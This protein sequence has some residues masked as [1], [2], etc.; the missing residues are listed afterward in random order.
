MLSFDRSH[1]T[2]LRSTPRPGRRR[3]ISLAVLVSGLVLST[4]A[5]GTRGTETSSAAGPSGV[6]AVQ[7]YDASQVAY[8]LKGTEGALP[9]SSPKP[10]PGK[11]VWVISC[12]QASTGCAT[13]ANDA[14]TAGRT[15]GW[16]MTL[17]DGKLSLQGWTAGIQAAIAAHAD[18]IILDYLDCPLVKQPL[19]DARKSGIRV[20]GINSFDCDDPAFGANAAQPMF[21]AQVQYAP[22]TPSVDAVQAAW[23]RIE[24]DWLLSKVGSKGNLLYPQSTDVTANKLAGQAFAE[25]VKAHC[26]SCKL[27]AVEFTL[28]DY[29]TGK[30]K[31]GIQTA[32]QSDPGIN[33][34]NSLG[35]PVM[36]SAVGPVLRGLSAGQRNKIHAIAGDGT[37]EM[38]NAAKQNKFAE[39]GV[40]APVTWFAWSAVDALNRVFAGRPQVSSGTGLRLWTA[41][42][43]Q[44]IDPATNSYRSAADFITNYK[45]IWGA[46]G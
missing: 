38:I 11:R 12:G 34:V 33:G 22:E 17:Y 15:I 40:G 41:D 9:T 18:G 44:N 13:P 30:L 10:Q 23:G 7:A 8:W 46:A 16:D 35:S 25:E 29:V 37:P 4:G 27:H 32:L 3:R 14:M 39:A 42:P 31:S 2:R 6:D 21:S 20:V 45:K 1:P 28:D 5:C 43:D 36:I 24:A 19:E 26:P